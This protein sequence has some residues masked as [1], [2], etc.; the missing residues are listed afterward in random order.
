MLEMP[1]EWRFANPVALAPATVSDLHDL[2]LKVRSAGKAPA[3]VDDGPH[4]TI[5]GVMLHQTSAGPR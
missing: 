1:Q 2:I 3:R 5:G 4:A